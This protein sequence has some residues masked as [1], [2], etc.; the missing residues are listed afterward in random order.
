M[1]G[2]FQFYLS[3]VG[4]DAG[5]RR[6]SPGLLQHMYTMQ[7][8]TGEGIR[9]YDFLRGQE[10]YK[11]DLGATDVVNWGFEA[12]RPAG[13]WSACRLS[14]WRARQR[15]GNRVKGLLRRWAR[16]RYHSGEPRTD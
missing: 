5:L 3:G 8:L 4:E 13:G 9:I 16:R 2:R 10:R 14:I 12:R 7:R 11:Y 6:H 1:A 15:L